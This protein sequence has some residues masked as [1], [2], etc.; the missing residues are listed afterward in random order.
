[1]VRNTAPPAWGLTQMHC[2]LVL[3]VY[4]SQFAREAERLS[5]CPQIGQVSGCARC[6]TR[7]GVSWEQTH[8]TVETWKSRALLSLGWKPA[9]L[10]VQSEWR[11]RPETRAE[12]KGSIPRL[13]QVL[14]SKYPVT[15]DWREAGKAVCPAQA[16]STFIL[17]PGLC[18]VCTVKGR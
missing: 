2:L 18:S 16:H 7:T 17:L 13:L 1:M 12:N 3:K 11:P 10:L 14:G 5:T 9:E 8:R 6:V 4:S 15:E